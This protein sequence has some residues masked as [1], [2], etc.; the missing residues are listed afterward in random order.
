VFSQEGCSCT[1]T[2]AKKFS[3]DLGFPQGIFLAGVAGSYTHLT[4]ILDINIEKICL[5]ERSSKENWD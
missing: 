4:N 5:C 2:P 3:S 1:T